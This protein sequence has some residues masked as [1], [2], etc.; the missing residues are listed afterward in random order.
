MDIFRAVERGLEI[1][2][3]YI[4]RDKIGV[5]SR[6]DTIYDKLDEIQGSSFGTNVTE[7]ACPTPS[8]CPP[9]TL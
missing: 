4:K 8:Q 5:F 2:V 6:E 3:G 1:E 9:G 7:V